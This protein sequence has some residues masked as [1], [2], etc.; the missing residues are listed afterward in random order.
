MSAPHFA[1]VFT[2]EIG[3]TPA[4][5]VEQARVEAARRR[6]EST[7]G[8]LDQIADACGFSSAEL[9]RRSFLRQLRVAPSQYR[10]HFRTP[11]GRA[12]QRLRRTTARTGCRPDP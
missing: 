1:R 6:L 2:Q 7:A 5:Y 10:K 9:L 4:R 8:D 11:S 12:P 3:V